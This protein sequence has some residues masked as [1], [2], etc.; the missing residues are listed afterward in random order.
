MHIRLNFHLHENNQRSIKNTTGCKEQIFVY[1][2]YI[3]RSNLHQKFQEKR[4]KLKNF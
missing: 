2:V 4:K 3:S 1:T